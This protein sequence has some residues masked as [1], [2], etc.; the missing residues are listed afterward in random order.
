M[1]VCVDRCNV[2]VVLVKGLSQFAFFRLVKLSSKKYSWKIIFAQIK[3]DENNFTSCVWW[4]LV[5]ITLRAEEMV[6]EKE[7][8]C[9]VRGYHVYKDMWAAAIGEVLVCN[10]EPT[11]VEKF[12]L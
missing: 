11:N 9:C 5:E 4:A 3:L 8:A 2:L 10:R 1:Y 7:M 6:C 12:S